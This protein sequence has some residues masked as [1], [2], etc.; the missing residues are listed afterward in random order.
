MSIQ[1]IAWVLEHSRSEGMDRLVLLAI[2]NHADAGGLNSWPSWERIGAEARV[3]RATVWRAISKLTA[4]GELMVLSG[5]R[6]RGDRSSYQVCLGFQH[7]TLNESFTVASGNKKGRVTR[8]KGSRSRD[9][10]PSLTVQNRA[11]ASPTSSAA[12]LRPPLVD[13][14]RDLTDEERQAGKEALA[15]IREAVSQ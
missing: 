10:E 8:Q 4:M 3:S 11:A 13:D 15:R 9:I 14:P 1:A 2:A 6:G 7:A 5:G 12:A